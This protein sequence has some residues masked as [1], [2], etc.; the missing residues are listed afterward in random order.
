MWKKIL[1]IS[2]LLCTSIILTS[3]YFISRNRE[4]PELWDAP[5]RIMDSDWEEPWLKGKGGQTYR[6]CISVSNKI[7]SRIRTNSSEFFSE[8]YVNHIPNKYENIVY[9]SLTDISPETTGKVL[10]LLNPPQGTYRVHQGAG[11]SIQGRGMD[12]GTRR[13]LAVYVVERRPPELAES[14]TQRHHPTRFG[15]CHTRTD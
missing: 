7:Y 10:D 12:A 13:A 6:G 14:C 5:I 8:I 2:F 4:F 3:P 11:T 15:E 9:L 1:L